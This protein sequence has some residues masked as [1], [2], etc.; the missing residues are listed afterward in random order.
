MELRQY[1][2]VDEYD[3]RYHYG[4]RLEHRHVREC[5]AFWRQV[6][7]IQH[8]LRTH[9][10]PGQQSNAVPLYRHFAPKL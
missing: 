3:L 7:A 8:I 9:A 10:G 1:L 4:R 6:G 5:T 2:A